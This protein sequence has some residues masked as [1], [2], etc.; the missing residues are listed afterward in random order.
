MWNLEGD[1][2]QFKAHR[3]EHRIIPGPTS[4]FFPLLPADCHTMFH[5]HFNNLLALAAVVA[6]VS[7]QSIDQCS[8]NC[9]EYAAPLC[10][11]KYVGVPVDHI[12]PCL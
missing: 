1:E 4:F 3:N 5:K 8:I 7:A 6:G 2:K 9:I 11:G 10:S 12:F